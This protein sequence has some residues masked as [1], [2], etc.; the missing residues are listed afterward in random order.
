MKSRILPL[1]G[2]VWGGA[3]LA[4]KGIGMV[5]GGSEQAAD[6]STGAYAAGHNAAVVF[7]ALI[8]FAGLYYF[9]KG[10]QKKA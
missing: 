7:G 10:S 5:L 8:F 1:I 4:F 3:I 2:I 6:P 9:F